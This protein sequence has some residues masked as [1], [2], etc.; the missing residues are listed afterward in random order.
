[1]ASTRE[2]DRLLRQMQEQSP[3]I[4]SGGS[5]ASKLAELQQ[6]KDEV[7]RLHNELRNKADLID[8]LRLAAERRSPKP[9]MVPRRQLD[10]TEEE[11]AQRTEVGDCFTKSYY[12]NL[13]Y[14]HEHFQ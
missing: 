8:R 14:L 2:K 10:D 9:D 6:A 13:A 5:A 11:L 4:F 7:A 3:D 1:M 12:L